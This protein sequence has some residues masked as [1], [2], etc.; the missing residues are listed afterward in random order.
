[1]ISNV[2]ENNILT[3]ILSGII[4]ENANFLSSYLMKLNVR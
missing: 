1:M 2:S 4:Y 3:L